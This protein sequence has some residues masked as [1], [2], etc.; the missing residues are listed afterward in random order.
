MAS[1]K[2]AREKLDEVKRK[3]EIME[4]DK[5]RNQFNPGKTGMYN[6]LKEEKEKLQVEL[7]SMVSLPEKQEEN[8]EEVDMGDLAETTKEAEDKE[9]AEDDLN[10]REG[11]ENKGF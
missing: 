5:S 6:E 1:E 9:T 4:W 11:K 7:N 3:L 2:E 10:A 8:S